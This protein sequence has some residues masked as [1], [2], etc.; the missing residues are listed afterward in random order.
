MANGP[1]TR[2]M[3]RVDS[4]RERL[5][6][7]YALCDQVAAQQGTQAARD[8]AEHEP[9]G[10][11]MSTGGTTELPLMRMVSGRVEVSL[12]PSEITSD[13]EGR[14]YAMLSVERRLRGAGRIDS[15]S[16]WTDLEDMG[17]SRWY[18]GAAGNKTTPVDAARIASWLRHSG[19]TPLW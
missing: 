14:Y 19:P 1:L 17:D 5:H 13:M 2:S 16:C 6:S 4:F 8:V 10:A 9:F 3:E 11:Q 18:A 7:L 15:P 12:R